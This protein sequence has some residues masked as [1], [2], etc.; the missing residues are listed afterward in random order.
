M[1]AGTRRLV[2]KRAEERCEYCR[3][4]QQHTDPRH[5]IEHVVSRQHGGLGD[6]A[7]LALACHRCKLHKG[8]NLTGIDPLTGEL[9]PLFHPRRDPCEARFALRGERIDG[10]TGCGRATVLALGEL[11]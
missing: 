7:N 2:R 1:D 11:G 8:P 6:E 5:H 9:S 4:Q 10:L 3:L